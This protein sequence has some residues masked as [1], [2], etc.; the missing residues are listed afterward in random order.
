MGDT[1]TGRYLRKIEEHLELIQKE[2]SGHIYQAAEMFADQVKQDKLIYAYGPGGH[3][4]LASQEIFFRAGG[5]FHVSAILDEG[6]LI[7]GG[8]LRSMAIERLPGYAKIVLDNY[9]L[10]KGDLLVI[11]NAYGINAATI[12][13]ALEAKKRG[14][15]TIGVTSV[16]HAQSTPPD[17][18]A[19]HPSKKNLYEL[20]D[21]VIDSKVEVGDAVLKIEG[22][23]HAVA[24]MSTFANA[25]ILNSVVAQAV[26]ILVDQGITPPMWASGNEAG[27]DEAN[28][29]YIERFKGRVKLL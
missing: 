14:V 6:T 10:K 15:K 28:D 5:L 21:L 1:V 22:L 11:T 24:A 2:E 26:Q 29:R 9:G 19:R 3:S 23:N 27:G 4:N 12:D 25:F 13:A 20:A 8:A 7:S 17:H 18:P 16:R